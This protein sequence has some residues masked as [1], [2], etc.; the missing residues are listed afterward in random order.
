MTFKLIPA[1]VKFIFF[2]YNFMTCK[3]PLLL[4]DLGPGVLPADV[5]SNSVRWEALGLTTYQLFTCLWWEDSSQTLLGSQYA[6]QP[7]NAFLKS[8]I[9]TV[10]LDCLLWVSVLKL[11]PQ[12]TNT[13]KLKLSMTQ[14]T[15]VVQTKS[16]VKDWGG[17]LSLYQP[18]KCNIMN[19]IKD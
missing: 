2:G 16:V 4:S 9:Q 14:S 19:I 18:Y 15:L 6:P 3:P 11:I 1:V 12:N 10:V 13:I 7:A 8:P 5:L 17:W